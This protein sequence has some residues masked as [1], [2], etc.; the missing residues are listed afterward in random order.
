[1]TI[2]AVHPLTFRTIRKKLAPRWLT[3]EEGELVGYALDLVRDGFLTRVFLGLLAR[4][5]DSAPDDA[6]VKLGRDRR[7]IRGL[8]ETKAG[9]AERLKRWLDDRK[10]AGNPFALMQKLAEYLG[11]LPSFRTVD[12][13]GN[14]FSRAADGT[15]TTLLNEGNWDWDLE[16]S[17]SSRWSRFWVIIYPNGLWNEGP[18]EWGDADLQGWGWGEAGDGMTWGSTAPADVVSTVRFIVSDWKPQGTRC[19][20]VIIAFD[21][22]SFT[23]AT[24][25]PDGLWE[26]WSKV[27]DGVRVPSR[28]DTARYWDGS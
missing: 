19:V 21:P 24:P 26:R 6:H 10:R 25:E 18:L 17:A 20:N 13:R 14:W 7:V 2:H 28:L 3:D 22:A 8:V 16:G 27:V 12:V 1:M 4:F 9:Y 5:P 23:P 11:P 15:E